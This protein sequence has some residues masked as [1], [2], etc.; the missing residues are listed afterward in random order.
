MKK[1]LFKEI[2]RINNFFTFHFNKI[3]EFVKIINQKFKKISSFNKYL[4]FFI[5]TLFLYLFYLSIPS[6]Y[7][8]GF[9]QAKLSKMI[10]EEYN[11]NLSLS[12]DINYNILPRPHI[13]IKNSKFYTND[14][15]S[16][17]ELGQIKKIKIFISQKNFFDQKNIEI[18]SILINQANFSLKAEDLNYLIKFIEKKFS[19][20][21]LNINNS[22]FFYIDD[23]ENVISIFPVK[24]LSLFFD[25][26][27]FQNFLSSRGK[28][29]TM[30]YRF[31][32]N[33]DFNKNIN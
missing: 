9:I 17:K 8:K 4:I 14:L 26:K 3:N 27:K 21:K 33:K 13:L 12:S 5:T 25:E 23:N 11:I 18:K 19:K 31:N 1:K 28:F 24:K 10:T 29:F 6:L 16:P 7:D 20:K 22:N 30:P 15:T 32:W 2:A